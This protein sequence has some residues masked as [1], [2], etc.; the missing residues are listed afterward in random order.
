[1]VDFTFIYIYVNCTRCDG[2]DDDYHDDGILY[3]Y[4][5][6]IY[7]PIYNTLLIHKQRFIFSRQDI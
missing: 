1:M 7:I 2:D 6:V 3:I 5:K 4:T